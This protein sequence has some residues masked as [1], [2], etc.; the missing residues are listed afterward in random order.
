MGGRR[1]RQTWRGVSS[2]VG[3]CR[4]AIPGVPCGGRGAALRMG[5]YLHCNSTRRHGPLCPRGPI[6]GPLLLEIHS[7]VYHAAAST[8]AR[9]HTLPGWAVPPPKLAP[10]PAASH[11]P[12]APWHAKAHI[13]RRPTALPRPCP[14]IPPK[15]AARTASH[16]G[17]SG[18][19]PF[20]MP[21]CGIPH[22]ILA[23]PLPGHPINENPTPKGLW[24]KY[25]ENGS[26]PIKIYGICGFLFQEKTKD[27]L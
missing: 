20:H 18:F 2:G 3:G 13:P 23:T 16:R 25:E 6:L 5:R 24:E 8:H 1:G 7:P 14:A 12:T 27:F 19:L 10:N 22:R 11:G 21:S 26:F 17:S 15:L 4:G 9:A